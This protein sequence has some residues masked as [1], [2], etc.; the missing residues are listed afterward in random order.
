MIRDNTLGMKDK[1]ISVLQT[2]LN[3]FPKEIPCYDEREDKA[4]E[5]GMFVVHFAGAWAHLKAEDGGQHPDPV[6]ALMRKYVD[7]VV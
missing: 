4:W 1:S 5:K 2:K 6:G 3:A 7:E